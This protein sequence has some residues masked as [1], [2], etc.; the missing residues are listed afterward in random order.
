MIRHLF[1]RFAVASIL[2]SPLLISAAQT[3]TAPPAAAATGDMIDRI[4][5]DRE[6]TLRP[7]PQ[8][9]WLDRGE[10]YAVSE[11]PDGSDQATVVRY[12]SATGARREAL[13]TPA[14]LT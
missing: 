6:F 14:P 11:R 3:A 2:A 4:F 9:Q 10:S 1:H 12:N 5:R 13:I 8:V 7:A